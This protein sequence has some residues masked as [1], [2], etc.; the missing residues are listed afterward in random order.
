MEIKLYKALNKEK[1]FVGVLTDYD[2]ETI[3][4]E[5]DDE[6]IMVFDRSDVALI[7]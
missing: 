5:L 4:I 7:R 2:K 6:S 1:E 3:T